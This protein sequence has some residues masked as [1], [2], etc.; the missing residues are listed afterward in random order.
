MAESPEV[1]LSP[2]YRALL[3][4]AV[5]YTQVWA[6]IWQTEVAPVKLSETRAGLC[7]TMAEWLGAQVRV[8][9]VS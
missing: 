2:D 4:S 5:G 6:G 1:R 9:L 3:I 7:D 8:L